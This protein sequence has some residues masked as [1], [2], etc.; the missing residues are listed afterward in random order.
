M[1]LLFLYSAKKDANYVRSYYYIHSHHII[2]IK[3]K[4]VSLLCGRQTA[5]EVSY[6][7]H[8]VHVGAQIVHHISHRGT[9]IMSCIAL[10]DCCRRGQIDKI[11]VLKRRGSVKR[12]FKY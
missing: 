9:P 10:G 3:L 2:I 1:F 8:L 6:V 11:W 12:H 5:P 4:R 7:G